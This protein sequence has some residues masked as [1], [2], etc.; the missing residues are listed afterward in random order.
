MDLDDCRSGHDSYDRIVTIAPR[1]SML[2]ALRILRD[3][4]GTRVA[5]SRGRASRR[6]HHG[7]RLAGTGGLA[8]AVL[9]AAEGLRPPLLHAD[10]PL[11]RATVDEEVDL[12]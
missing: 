7:R 4:E 2:E 9:G 10:D 3:R 12:A 8:R 6:A 5:H 11:H 1:A